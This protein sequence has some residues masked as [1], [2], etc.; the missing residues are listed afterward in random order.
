VTPTQPTHLLGTDTVVELVRGR[1]D[2]LLPR[3]DAQPGTLAVSTITLAALDYGVECSRRPDAL[4]QD[5][6]AML[7]LLDVLP[8]DRAAAHHAGLIRHA[9]AATGTPISPYDTLIAGH[10]LSLGLVPVTHT[11]R[12]FR[13]VPGLVVEDWMAA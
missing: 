8:F 5:I 1:A 3:L 11:T 10:A 9:L 12:E 6:E 4:R 2:H 7:T 13:R